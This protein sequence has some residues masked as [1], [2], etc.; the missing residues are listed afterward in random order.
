MP[1][2]LILDAKATLGESPWWN[3]E[4]QL[5]YWVDIEEHSLHVTN[6]S[7]GLDNE[8]NLGQRIGAVVGRASGGCLLAMQNGFYSFDFDSKDLRLIDDPEHHL[9]ENRFN[10]GKCD[11]AGRFWA[12]TMSMNGG[13][14]RGSLY[15]LDTDLTVSRMIECVSCSN[16]LA[17]S[18]DEATMYFIDTPTRQ[19]AAY[20]YQKVTGLIANRRVVIET[21]SFLGYPDGM[22]A[23]QEGMLW[24]CFWHGSRICR[25]SPKT[26]K[27]LQ[28]IDLPV[29]R[30]TSCAFGGIDLRDL[31]ITS[32]S[33]GLECE[34]YAGAIFSY[35]ADVPGIPIVPFAG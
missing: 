28:T 14:V 33:V 34:Q 21:P 29:S 15:C 31:Y 35:R 11:P 9:P 13:A 30:P 22:S 2:D 25:W 5:L 3:A 26:G 7:S 32:A 8:I 27:C 1:L 6:P 12:G 17:W 18:P 24:I 20:D 19:V 10:D 4:E 23:D 16:G